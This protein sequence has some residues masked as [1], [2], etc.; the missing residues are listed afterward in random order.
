MKRPLPKLTPILISL[1]VLIALHSACALALPASTRAQATAPLAKAAPSLRSPRLLPLTFEENQGQTDSSVKYLA[2]GAGFELFLTD[3]KSVLSIQGVCRTTASA[4]M[5][6]VAGQRELAASKF[7][8]ALVRHFNRCQ[9][10]KLQMAFAGANPA[11]LTGVGELAAKSSYFVGRDPSKWRTGIPNYA[12]VQY[13]G[14]YRGVNLVFYGSRGHLEFDFVVAPGADPHQIALNFNPAKN[15]RVM[16]DGDLQIGPRSSAI[17]LLRPYIYQMDGQRTRPIRGGFALLSGG[18]VGLRVGRYDHAEPLIVDPVLTYSTF[19]NGAGGQSEADAIAVDSKGDAYVVGSTSSPSFPTAN[20]YQ[21]SAGAPANG[22]VFLSKF[23]PTGTQLLYSTYLGGT[24]GDTATGVAIDSA[25]N[26]YITGY[27]F[28]T[29]FPVLNAFQSVNNNPNAGNAF[30]AKINTS[31]SGAASLVYSSYLGGGGS[32][33][34][35][36]PWYGDSGLGIAADSAGR[37]FVTG[38]TVSDTSVAAFPTTSNAYQTSL[39]SPNG[40]AF[41]TVVDTTRSGSSSLVYSTYLGGDGAGYFG[42]MGLGVATDGSGN[43][44]IVGQTTSDGSGP[45]PTTSGAYQATLNGA[46]GNGFLTEIA[47]TKS[48][49]SSL[50]YS[51]Y[52]GGAATGAFG[53]SADAVALDSAGNVYV[54]G[55]AASSNFPTTNGAVQMVNSANG[56]PFV[57]KFNLAQSGTSSLVFSTLLG[58]TN[59]SGGQGAAG[60]AVDGSGDTFIVG[61][62]SA[63][64]FPVTSNAYQNTYKSTAGSNAFLSELDPSASTLLYSTYLGGSNYDLATGAALDPLGDPYVVGYTESSDFPTTAGSLQPTMEGSGSAFVSEMSNPNG[65]TLALSANSTTATV[66]SGQSATYSLSVMSQGTFNSP[67]TFACNGLPEYATCQFSPASVTGGSGTAT[68]IL[69]ITTEENG[70][71]LW[72]PPITPASGWPISTALFAGVLLALIALRTAFVFGAASKS[73]RR[74]ILPLAAAFALATVIGCGSTHSQHSQNSQQPPST[75]PGTSQVTVQA[76]AQTAS[77]TATSSV[78]VALTVN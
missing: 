33:S 62:T 67:I 71:A 66:T 30:I 17:R 59:S 77:G 38:D 68:T 36:N 27:T 40:D 1:T 9:T 65:A 3:S 14:L 42:D 48:G 6:T 50:V 58:G 13:A 75:P 49:L 76:S 53:D 7:G 23:N 78:T 39:S 19:L 57:A 37:A 22:I 10:S 28:S 35:P 70:S 11:H 41:L 72:T 21:S 16:P 43:A 45:F 25:G 4:R 29:D 60:I 47:T 52:F 73:R 46:S 24:G 74:L 15:V 63:S 20:P 26:A 56:K 8:R 51:T 69:T 55:Y 44:Y 5:F 31:Q 54:A 34:N 12:R 2:R 18:R 64:D 32:T 61:Q